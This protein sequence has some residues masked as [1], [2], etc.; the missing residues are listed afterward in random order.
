[1]LARYKYRGDEQLCD[2]FAE[3]LCYSYALTQQTDPTPRRTQEI[4]TYV[5][6]SSARLVERGFNQAEQMA[7]SLGA[8]LRLPVVP[9]LLRNRHTEKQSLKSRNERLLDLQHVFAIDLVGRE[10]LTSLPITTAPRIYIIDDVYTTGSTLAECASI[11]QESVPF[12]SVY[13]LTWAR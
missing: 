7:Q 8:K 6:L 12:A 5:P 10:Q 9:L 11:I 3:M 13:G 4:L 2:L 1:M